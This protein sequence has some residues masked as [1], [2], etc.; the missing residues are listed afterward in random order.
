MELTLME[1]P[2]SLIFLYF[3]WY[4]LLGW[5]METVYCSVR[6]GA[7]VDRGFLMGPICPIYGV[8]ALLMLSFLNRFVGSPLLFYVM[9]VVVMSAWEY[10][11]G[12]FLDVTTHIKYWDYSKERWN[13]HGRI[14]LKSSL[15][16]GIIAY[17][18]ICWIHPATEALF[19]R[20]MPLPREIL[21]G[22]LLLLT[23]VDTGY[24]VHNLALAAKFLQKAAAAQRE[25][26]E[27]R[28]GLQS[29]LD[30]AAVQASL[31]RLELKER[32]LLADTAHYLRRFRRRYENLRAI[33]CEEVFN[34]LVERSEQLREYRKERIAAL[35]RQRRKKS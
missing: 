2:L 1:Q 13:L 25:W 35:K 12:W 30:E 15:Y 31:L 17:V 7:F 27:L 16:W 24:T 3:I 34:A 6:R 9:A 10:L 19:A 33:D 20:L 21:A 8:G 18:A 22:V 29:R 4:S 26:E 11:V 5:I 28:Q 23:L 32:D 14:C